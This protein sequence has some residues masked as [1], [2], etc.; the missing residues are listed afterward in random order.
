[1][2]KKPQLHPYADRLSFERILLLI[3]TLINHPGIGCCNPLDRPKKGQHHNALEP[4][5]KKEQEFA[6]SLGIT[7]PDNY[8]SIGTLRKDLETLREFGILDRRMYRWGYYLGTGVMSWEE[9][10]VAF[11]ALHSQAVYQGDPTIREIYQIL[12]KRLRGLDLDSNGDFSYPVRA[13]LN[14]PIIYTDPQ[15]MQAKGKN[16]H[17]L[18]HCLDALEVAIAK[19]QLVELYRHREP[20]GQRTGYIQVYPLQLFYHDIAWYLL[21][22]YSENQHLEVGRLDRFKDYCHHIDPTGRGQQKQRE[23]LKEAQKLMTTG[24][25]I[26]LGTPCDQQL[27]RQGKLL[28]E[29][30]KVRFFPPVTT[31]ILEGECRHPHQKLRAKKDSNGEYIHVDYMIKLPPRS[32]HEFSRWVYRYMGCAQV[33]SPPD[34]VEKHRQAAQAVAARYR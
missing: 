6:Q 4:L 29:E 13:Y 12:E 16:R 34:L 1:M 17:T 24:W 11:N 5:Q 32:F 9:L 26:Y 28:L 8:P 14:R 19:G 20:Y 23:S 7:F 27:E 21:Y 30:V 18:F 10:K 31:F 25:G 22:E 33:L 3:A 15:Q 2:P